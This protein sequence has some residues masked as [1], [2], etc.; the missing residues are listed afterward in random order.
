LCGSCKSHED[1]E[2]KK[3]RKGVTAYP[4]LLRIWKRKAFLG[5]P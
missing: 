4:A 5:L 1:S 2:T 3:R